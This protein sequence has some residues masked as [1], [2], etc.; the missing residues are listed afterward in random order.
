M[1]TEQDKIVFIDDN[2][3]QKHYKE[4]NEENPQF[5]KLKLQQVSE[6]NKINSKEYIKKFKSNQSSFEQILR[7]EE[8]MGKNL[9]TNC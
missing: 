3:K 5:E 2:K 9:H 4:E 6:K 8:R 1:D 7:F